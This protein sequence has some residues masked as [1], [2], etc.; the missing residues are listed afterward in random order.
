MAYDALDIDILIFGWTP[1]L[2][3]NELA[4]SGN[5]VLSK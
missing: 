4:R 2:Q 1:E 5:L 3:E